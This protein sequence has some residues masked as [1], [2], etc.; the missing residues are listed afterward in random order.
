M[1]VPLMIAG[2]HNNSA[3]DINHITGGNG[4][5]IMDNVMRLNQMSPEEFAAQYYANNPGA[6]SFGHG[7]E[8]H[9]GLESFASGSGGMRDFGGG[10]LAM[11]HG[12]ESVET[13]AQRSGLEAEIR[14]LR[15]DM[16]YSLPA[17][18]AKAVATAN[19]KAGRRG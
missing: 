5:S 17:I 9:M 7:G 6:E 13:E 4:M 16:T 12:R 3:F 1:A 2:F 14:G 15:R 10:T 8:S 11:L 19:V 18:L